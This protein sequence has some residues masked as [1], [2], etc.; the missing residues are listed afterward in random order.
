MGFQKAI[1]KAIEKVQ[2]VPGV[3]EDVTV[4][5]V[6]TGAYNSTTGAIAETLSDTTVKGVFSDVNQREVNDLVQADDRKCSIPAASV[7][8]I[9]TTADRIVAGGVSYQIIRVHTVSQAGTNLLYELFLR[10]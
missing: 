9:P 5:S 3:G 1:Q 10:A 4:R 6:S 7:S 8:S 2:Q